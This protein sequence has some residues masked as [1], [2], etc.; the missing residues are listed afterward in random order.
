MRDGRFEAYGQQLNIERG[1]LSFQG[2]LDNPAL[3]VRAIRSGLSVEAGVQISGNAQKPVIKLISD[4]DLPDA[5]KLAWL[6]LGHGP[7]Q[8]GA[9]DASILLSAAGGLLGNDSG[10][11][12][13]Q[14]KSSFGIDEF[15]VRT[16]QLGDAGSRQRSS[17][18][19]G[20]SA[21]TTASTGNQILSV[22]KRLS[23]NAVLSYEQALGKAESVVKLTVKLNR[24]LSLIGR[25]GSDN[26]LDMFYTL[27]FGR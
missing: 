20:G 11:V 14:L 10:G 2:L 25:A 15:G 3:D 12:I 24:Q 7:E 13:Q 22:G 26:A 23:S 19:A 8:L 5:E 6:V 9:G 17:R 21:D 16:G 27:T 1:I 18:V 4:P